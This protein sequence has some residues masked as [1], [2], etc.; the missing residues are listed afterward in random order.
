MAL[1][2]TAIGAYPK[3]NY[4]PTPDWF[5]ASRRGEYY[6]FDYVDEYERELERL[7]DEA[8]AIFVTASSP[9]IFACTGPSLDR[10]QKVSSRP[11]R[12]SCH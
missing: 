6:T 7:G 2:T 8:E 12:P 9:R 3:P 1:L 11:L 10:P 4:V 5:G